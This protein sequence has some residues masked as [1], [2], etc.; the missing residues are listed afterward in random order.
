MGSS[1]RKETLGYCSSQPV[2]WPNFPLRIAHYG[3]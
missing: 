2:L 3:G 1:K